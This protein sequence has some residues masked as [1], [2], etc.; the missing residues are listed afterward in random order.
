[1]TQFE[2]FAEQWL[3]TGDPLAAARSM[4]LVG[5]DAMLAA[6]DWPNKLEVVVA[7]QELLEAH[8]PEH[9]LPTKHDQARSV[10]QRAQ[11]CSDP[12]DYQKLMRLYAEI[13]GNLAPKKAEVQGN[14]GHSIIFEMIT[15]AANKP[16]IDITPTQKQLT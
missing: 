1:M 14:M 4:G 6:R 9:F 3:R 5:S 15:P 13:M 2:E 10:W 12:D 8:G 11:E 16:V 7:K